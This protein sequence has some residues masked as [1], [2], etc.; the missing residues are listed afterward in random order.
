MNKLKTIATEWKLECRMP[1][2][3]RKGFQNM[4][5][6]EC[7]ICPK[8]VPD[9]FVFFLMMECVSLSIIGTDW[10]T[11]MP[12]ATETLKGFQNM[13]HLEC[14]IYAPK[15]S[16]GSDFFSSWFSYD[17]GIPSAAQ[18]LFLQAFLVRGNKK[19]DKLGGIPSF[20]PSP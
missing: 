9:D 20:S 15:T 17:G 1:L 4:T 14:P 12:D 2:E 16:S 7:P 8:K 19:S 10:K 3:Y 11:K 18:K 5:L 6:L 13:T